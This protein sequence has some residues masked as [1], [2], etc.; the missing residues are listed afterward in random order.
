[1]KFNFYKYVVMN[2]TNL[3]QQ[4][5]N[6]SEVTFVIKRE[7]YEWTSKLQFTSTELDTFADT[8]NELDE[9]ITMALNTM[10]RTYFPSEHA[11][12]KH[13][14]KTDKGQQLN[15]DDWL[16]W[17]WHRE[18]CNQQSK[19]IKAEIKE[20]LSE[21][22]ILSWHWRAALTTIKDYDFNS[23]KQKKI[24]IIQISHFRK[25]EMLL[26]YSVDSSVLDEYKNKLCRIPTQAKTLLR[27]PL[28][29]I[30]HRLKGWDTYRLFYD[31]KVKD[32]IKQEIGKAKN[33]EFPISDILG[34]HDCY[35]VVQSIKDNDD[36]YAL[37]L[38]P[39][40]ELHPEETIFNYGI[41]NNTTYYRPLDYIEIPAFGN[42][43]GK[44]DQLMVSDNYCEAIYELME[45]LND[46][47]VKSVLIIA[48][49]GS[50]KEQ[51]AKFAF[52]CRECI[53]FTIRGEQ[54]EPDYIAT[55]LAGLNATEASK[56]L[57]TCQDATKIPDNPD[58]FKEY[59]ISPQD[60]LIIRALDGA[61]FVDEIDKADKSVRNLLLRVLESE[62]ITDPHTSKVIKIENRVPFYI[63]SG[64][65][66]RKD[67]FQESPPDFW[68]RISHIIEIRHPLEYDDLEKG[69]KVMKDYLWMFWT[70][71]VEKVLK[72]NPL[73]NGN[74]K[75]K[76]NTS[77]KP[78][79]DY[80]KDLFKFLLDKITVNFVCDILTDELCGRGKPIVSI[81]T[82]RSIIARSFFRLVDIIRFAKSEDN[83]IE[84]YKSILRKEEPTK[85]LYKI[86]HEIMLDPKPEEMKSFDINNISI[87]DLSYRKDV[88]KSLTNAIRE[89]S[90]LS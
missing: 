40:I 77:L 32:D 12:V 45:V 30:S 6:N 90:L 9:N 79:V 76:N 71:H 17:R 81:R 41:F 54:N 1:M 53:D 59:Q 33:D 62:E 37:Q 28:F 15:I 89:G 31:R 18:K 72:K 38:T 50:G 68:T 20:K 25:W 56:L 67:M 43:V 85:E 80:E 26:C 61:L 29:G 46:S 60:G 27:A 70:Q 5:S 75:Y 44:I 66:S 48:P 21:S 64:S 87:K 52:Y 49:P 7:K 84:K 65:M 2:N 57:F 58:K 3:L 88:L 82:L 39:Q 13:F 36:E 10:F 22:W 83:A 55:T 14:E 51:F 74:G 69:K 35:Y 34:R 78:L 23:K 4:T 63:F 16:P 11:E 86:M 42:K 47:T 73:I 19:D 24:N 8:M